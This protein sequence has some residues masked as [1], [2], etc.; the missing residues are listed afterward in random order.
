MSKRENPYVGKAQYRTA[1]IWN[2][3]YEAAKYNARFDKV[4]TTYQQGVAAGRELER[5]VIG[6]QLILMAQEYGHAQFVFT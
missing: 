5:D 1:D 2:E 4:S 3:G 6:Q